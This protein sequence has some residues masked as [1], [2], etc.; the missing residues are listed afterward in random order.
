MHARRRAIQAAA[1]CFVLSP[2]AAEAQ[3]QSQQQSPNQT[4]GR[5]AGPPNG[6]NQPTRQRT[7]EL[8][9]KNDVAPTQ[10]KRRQQLKTLNQLNQKLLPD[11]KPPAPS[12]KPNQ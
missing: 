1:I 9:R 10:Q 6:S 12:V 8:L 3:Q 7:Q 5:M 4:P 2:A 11:A